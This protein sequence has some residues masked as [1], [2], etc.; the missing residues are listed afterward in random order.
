MSNPQRRESRTQSD[1]QKSFEIRPRQRFHFGALQNSLEWSTPS[2][3][4][5]KG[6]PYDFASLEGKKA[7][8]RAIH[9]QIPYS[10]PGD[11]STCGFSDQ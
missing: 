1:T 10:G 3:A 2:S 8:S 4:A 5:T 7:T 9:S 6:G 11:H